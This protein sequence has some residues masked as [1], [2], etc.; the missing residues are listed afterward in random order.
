VP[1]WARVLAPIGAAV[2]VLAVTAGYLA[3][4]RART[5]S[6][7]SAVLPVD[8]TASA[9]S[10]LSLLVTGGGLA[11]LVLAGWAF[12]RVRVRPPVA[13]VVT[14]VGLAAAALL[15]GGG[16]MRLQ[17]NPGT[18]T[19]VIAPEDG[20]GITG[21]W[22]VLAAGTGGLVP[23]GSLL[24]VL[25]MTGLAAVLIGRRRTRTAVRPGL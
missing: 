22:A 9:A 14:G 16:L 19:G 17:T 2:C 7:G 23:A 20:W 24:L 4:T 25:W 18:V 8:S 11:L 1:R 15:C 3:E 10:G 13:R 21:Y 5:V 12:G 6:A